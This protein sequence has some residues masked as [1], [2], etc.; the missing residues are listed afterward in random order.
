MSETKPT[1]GALRAARVICGQWFVVLARI[2]DRETGVGELL[3]ALKPLT[4]NLPFTHDIRLE[5]SVDGRNYVVYLDKT[6]FVQLKQAI[7][8]AEGADTNSPEVRR[9]RGAM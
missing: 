3:E 9:A 4:I 1:A 8:K 6:H 2:I 7:A 5:G